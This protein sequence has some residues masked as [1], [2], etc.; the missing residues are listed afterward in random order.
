[1]KV[2]VL[3]VGSVR[4]PLAEAVRDFESRA[5][6]YWR[7]RV[8]DVESGAGRGNSADPEQVRRAEEQRLLARIPERGE[9]VAL[10]REGRSMGS[11]DVADFLQERAVRSV[12]EVTFVIG[13]AFGL[14]DGVL[15]KTSTTLSLSAMTLPHELARLVL[16]EQLY[17]AGTILKNEPY[18]KG[19]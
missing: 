1:V 5:G 15:R 12:P 18:H 17:R 8:I 10:T 9:V 6:R 13:G 7:L 3:V 2:T 4:G 19:P 16:A 11:R 14:G